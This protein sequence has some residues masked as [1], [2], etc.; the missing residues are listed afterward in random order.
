MPAAVEDAPEAGNH[1]IAVQK[2]NIVFQLH[3]FVSGPSIQSAFLRQP[4][5]ILLRR[6]GDHGIFRLRLWR[7]RRLP[8]RQILSICD[9]LRRRQDHISQSQHSG[10]SQRH[11]RHPFHFP[12][13]HALSL[14]FLFCRRFLLSPSCAPAPF[15]PDFPGASDAGSSIGR[16]QSS[17]STLSLARTTA[18][19]SPSMTPVNSPSIMP[20]T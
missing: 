5:Q 1:Q 4:A 17:S 3:I 7:L 20:F 12:L 18:P 14:P 13:F 16:Q 11:P 6:Y 2:H 19:I 8:S 10:Q 15:S 9:G